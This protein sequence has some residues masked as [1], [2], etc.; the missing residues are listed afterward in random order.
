MSRLEDSSKKF[1]IN[2]RNIFEKLSELFEN[3]LKYFE[4][5]SNK[6]LKYFGGSFIKF[7]KKLG[8]SFGLEELVDKFDMIFR[9]LSRN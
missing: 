5:S 9:K 6:F 4:N 1:R 7:L 2:F 8:S 3:I